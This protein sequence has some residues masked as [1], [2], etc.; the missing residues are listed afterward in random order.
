[1]ANSQQGE[2]SAAWT[3]GS[4][5]HIL[6]TVA[7]GVRPRTL[8]EILAD[9]CA[10]IVR[11]TPADAHDACSTGALLIDIRSDTDREHDG[12]VPGSLHIPRTVLEWRADP[13]GAHRNPYL[14]GLDQ[15]L[16]L[17]CD[18]GCS[19]I[20]A[21]ANLTELGYTRAGD[22]I[23]GFAA[24]QRARLPTRMPPTQRRRPSGEPAGMA[25]PDG[26]D[27]SP[28]ESGESDVFRASP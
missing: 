21:A 13:D 22:V 16:I 7:A 15:Q 26:E 3:P 11:Y 10:K 9:A 23:G 27:A 19:T 6:A 24:W 12:I 20:L 4:D 14:A 8:E 17:L 5:Q 28:P 1:M 18:H 25:G 2:A